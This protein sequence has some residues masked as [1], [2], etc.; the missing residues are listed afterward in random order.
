MVNRKSIPLPHTPTDEELVLAVLSGRNIY[1]T[2]VVARYRHKL[3]LYLRHLMGGYDEAEDLLQNVFVKVYEHLAEFDRERKF[4]SWIYRIAHNEAV[5]YLKKRSRRYLIAWDD[6]VSSKDK[7][8]TAD[9]KDTPEETWVRGELRS[10]VRTAL[11]RLPKKYQEVII[12]RFYLDKSY[13]EIAQI[14]DRPENTVATL[15]NRAKKRLV[16]LLNEAGEL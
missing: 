1:F 8:E 14:I 3:L 13:A 12:L 11:D 6:I 4:S 5:N 9:G 10:E 16:V 7:L 15:L 2:E